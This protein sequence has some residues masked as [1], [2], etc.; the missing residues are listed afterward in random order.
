MNNTCP[1]GICIECE[2]RGT[3]DCESVKAMDFEGDG[4]NL[5]MWGFEHE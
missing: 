1:L 4:D 5:N 2:Y 3:V